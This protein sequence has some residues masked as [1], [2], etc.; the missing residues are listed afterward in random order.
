MTGSNPERSF[1]SCKLLVLNSMWGLYLVF[2]FKNNNYRQERLKLPQKGEKLLN[3][4]HGLQYW[5]S[6][7]STMSGNT[8]VYSALCLG[9]LRV[10]RFGDWRIYKNESYTQLR[11]P[12]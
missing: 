2:T 1:E 10:D 11:E 4:G 8:V 5:M 12:D 9:S 7:A 6:L 3:E